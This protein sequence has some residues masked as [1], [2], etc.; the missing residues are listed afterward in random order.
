MMFT[1]KHCFRGWWPWY[2]VQN[3]CGYDFNRIDWPL[4]IILFWLIFQGNCFPI[5]SQTCL[6]RQFA[7]QFIIYSLLLR[8][9]TLLINA[10]LACRRICSICVYEIFFIIRCRFDSTDWIYWFY[11]NG[12]AIGIFLIRISFY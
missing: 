8:H 7:I 3:V 12:I 10:F 11:L 2:H 1:F 9:F 5:F 4:R 6:K